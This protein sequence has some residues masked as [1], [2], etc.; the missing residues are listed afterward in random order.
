ML[1]Q[2][3]LHTSWTLAQATPASVRPAIMGKQGTYCEQVIGFRFNDSNI[4]TGF[5]DCR[6][7]M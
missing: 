5:E 7:L 2:L 4:S 6:V 1:S 3:S